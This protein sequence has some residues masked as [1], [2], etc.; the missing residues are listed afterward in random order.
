VASLI[1]AGERESGVLTD[2]TAF[3]GRVGNDISVA[4]IGECF[5]VVE[6]D[7]EGC[8]LSREP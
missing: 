1:Y 4:S 7:M 2:E 6:R 5:G 8:I 3:V